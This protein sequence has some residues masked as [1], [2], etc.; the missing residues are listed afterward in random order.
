MKVLRSKAL[1]DDIAYVS[2]RAKLGRALNYG[3]D[4]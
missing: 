1:Q 4:Q 3:C 2:N